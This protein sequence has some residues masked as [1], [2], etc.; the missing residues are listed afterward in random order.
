[1]TGGVLMSVPGAD[2]PFRMSMGPMVSMPLREMYKHLLPRGAE[3]DALKIDAFINGPIGAGEVWSQL[4]PT[5]VRKFYTALDTDD[6][7]SALASSMNGA[8][9]NL[10]AAGLVPTT[11]N[12]DSAVAQQFRDRLQTQVRNHSSSEPC[13]ACL[14][15]PR[16]ALPP[17]EPRRRVLT[18]RG[19]WMGSSSS[20]TSTR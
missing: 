1:M 17:R 9:A 13:S 14:R 10:A 20:A 11:E 8:I 18:T 15:R 3:A 2:N 12:A 5:A 7:N 16:P 4:V 6:R 19:A